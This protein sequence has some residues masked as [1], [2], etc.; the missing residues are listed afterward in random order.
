[1]LKTKEI[2]NLVLLGIGGS[3]L[4][5]ETIFNA[6]LHPYHNYDN[7]ARG[8]KPRYFIVDN[9]DPH[10]IN[11]MIEIIKPELNKT[12]LVVISKS[13]ETPETISRL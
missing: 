8:E 9:I 3:A 1:M 6:L 7:N 5:A 13:G 10:K 2:K 12:L 11:A 4:G